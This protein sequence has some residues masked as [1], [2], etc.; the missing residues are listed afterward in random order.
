MARSTNYLS[1]QFAND[2]DGTGKLSARA[3]A[4]G[5]AGVGEA[6][7]NTENIE[8]FARSI[9]QYPLEGTFE[10]SGGLG[11]RGSGEFQE[12]LAVRVYAI[13]R[14][15]HVAVQ[16]RMATSMWSDVKP[17]L[18][19]TAKVEVLTSHEPLRKFSADL[20]SLLRGTRTEAV[21]EGDSG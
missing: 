10:I 14:R 9:A 21:L 17:P 1:L 12:H 20:I 15:G 7:F 8:S 18:Q 2:G 13:D 19:M 4:P 6:Y 16:V 3:E 5:F 11:E